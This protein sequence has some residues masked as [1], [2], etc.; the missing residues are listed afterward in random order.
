MRHFQV[1]Y[2]LDFP[3]SLSLPFKPIKTIEYMIR[4]SILPMAPN[5]STKTP[6][7]GLQN[8]ESYQNN[9][10]NRSQ[11][12]LKRPRYLPKPQP[13]LMVYRKMTVGIRQVEPATEGHY[14]SQTIAN[15]VFH[16]SKSRNNLI[17]T[18]PKPQERKE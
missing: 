16:V 1:Y 10:P 4:Q 7:I 9:L 8:S 3:T 11:R 14:A 18:S 12:Y 15:N 2:E 5:Q 17:Q 6:S 13:P